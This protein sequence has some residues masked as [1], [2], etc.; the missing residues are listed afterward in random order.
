MAG[1]S[2]V[3]P[4]GIT[5]DNCEIDEDDCASGPCLNDGDCFDDVGGFR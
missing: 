5:G 1:Y 4:D 2:C 3:C